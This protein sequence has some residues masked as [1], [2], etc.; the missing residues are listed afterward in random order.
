VHVQLIFDAQHVG[1]LDMKGA[2]L[3]AN[4]CR[5]PL[6][7]TALWERFC[8]SI[9]SEVDKFPRETQLHKEI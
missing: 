1:Q 7:Q 5:N 3:L 9:T 8:N 4:A 2:V 6:A